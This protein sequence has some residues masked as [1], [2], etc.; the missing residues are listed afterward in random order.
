MPDEDRVRAAEQFNRARSQF[1]Q[2]AQAMERA[3]IQSDNIE[4]VRLALEGLHHEILPYRPDRELRLEQ[5]DLAGPPPCHTAA[6]A[7]GQAD[8][9]AV[10]ADYPAREPGGIH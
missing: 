10:R 6:Q 9:Q 4:R 3:G 5:A 7:D 1:E 8:G 2:A